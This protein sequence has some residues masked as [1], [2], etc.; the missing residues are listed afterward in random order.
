M[1][2]NC[3]EGLPRG[4]KAL[5]PRRLVICLALSLSIHSLLLVQQVSPVAYLVE[6]RSTDGLQVSARLQ[7]FLAPQGGVVRTKLIP[8]DAPGATIASGRPQKVASLAS[9]GGG[10]SAVLP[11][12]EP[13]LASEIDAEIDDTRVRGF[14][15][16]HLLIDESGWVTESEVI[17]AE[18]PQAAADLLMKRFA[19]ARFKPAVRNGQVA[20]ASILLRIDID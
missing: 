1:D 8:A 4:W 12:K 5:M 17:Y 9:R 14:M 18:L 6:S 3:R 13:E 2:G 19:A 7:V 11:E 15:I 20:E 10:I 16:L